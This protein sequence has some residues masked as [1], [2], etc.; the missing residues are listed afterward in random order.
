MEEQNAQAKKKAVELAE[1]HWSDPTDQE[2]GEYLPAFG[3]YHMYCTYFFISHLQRDMYITYRLLVQ[4]N[5]FVLLLA[6][7]IKLAVAKW[8]TD[9]ED[10]EVKKN[11][12]N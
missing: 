7:R 12:Q 4:I 5:Q 8:L 10:S 1:R 11:Q 2:K 3:F 9:C 6:F